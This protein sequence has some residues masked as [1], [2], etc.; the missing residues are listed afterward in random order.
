MGS[1]IRPVQEVPDDPSQTSSKGGTESKEATEGAVVNQSSDLSLHTVNDTFTVWRFGE[2]LSNTD[3][4]QL[5]SSTP[6]TTP[7][8]SL[9]TN[10]TVRTGYW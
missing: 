7:Y 3:T 9:S 5:M 4:A 1:S 2:V 6:T 8:D 10:T